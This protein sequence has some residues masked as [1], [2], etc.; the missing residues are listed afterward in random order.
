[1]KAFQFRLQRVL[2]WRAA[3]VERQRLRVQ[4]LLQ[5][6][7]SL[8]LLIEKVRGEMSLHASG[9]VP[10]TELATFARYRE[11]LTRE[12]VR[13]TD[14]R[15]VCS[16]QLRIAREEL[17]QADRNLKLLERL[18]EK[19]LEGWKREFDHELESLAT[20]AFLARWPGK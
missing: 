2:E 5:E 14:R 1:M 17:M 8:S 9:I 7:E 18:K 16:E 4:N 3:G 20:E 11:R 15:R 13:V 19:R 10:G 12:L 6:L